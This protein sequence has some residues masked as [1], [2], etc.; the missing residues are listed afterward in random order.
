MMDG[1]RAVARIIQRFCRYNADIQS[2]VGAYLRRLGLLL[3][4]ACFIDQIHHSSERN[5]VVF[6]LTITKPSLR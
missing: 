1:K 3:G 5:T 6:A 4:R 2:P